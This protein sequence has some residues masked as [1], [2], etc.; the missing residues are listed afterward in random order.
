MGC[1]RPLHFPFII[2][3]FPFVIG[4][5]DVM[6]KDKSRLKMANDKSQMTNDKWYGRQQRNSSTN[7]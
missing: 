5:P 7:R 4:R 6:E 3:H 2:F 1:E